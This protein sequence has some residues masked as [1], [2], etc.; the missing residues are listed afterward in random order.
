MG[1]YDVVLVA[2]K[3]WNEMGR[4]VM[5]DYLDQVDLWSCLQGQGCLDYTNCSG[6]SQ[7]T[8]EPPVPRQGVLDCV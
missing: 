2:N 4:V 3:T 6:K 1:R 7:S 5:K 8:L